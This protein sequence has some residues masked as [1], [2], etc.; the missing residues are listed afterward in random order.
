V[1]VRKTSRLK[2]LISRPDLP[3]MPGAFDVIFGKLIAN[4]SFESA[5][6]SNC[7]APLA[8]SNMMISLPPLHQSSDYFTWDPI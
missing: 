1:D 7:I 6:R 4:A 2:Q 3:I 5:L 8:W